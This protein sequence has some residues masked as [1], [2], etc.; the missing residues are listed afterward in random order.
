[1]NY[2]IEIIKGH[3]AVVH[4][5]FKGEELKIGSRWISSSGYIVSLDKIEVRDVSSSSSPWYI[6]HYSWEENDKIITHDKDLFSFQSRY[7]LLIE[8]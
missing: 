2:E 6:V 5:W 3:K 8:D 4:H 1:M 7:Y